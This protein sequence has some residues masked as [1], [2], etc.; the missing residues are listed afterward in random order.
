MKPTAGFLIFHDD[1]V[2]FE[3]GKVELDDYVLFGEIIG[4]SIVLFFY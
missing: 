1:I 3:G 2:A 4:A